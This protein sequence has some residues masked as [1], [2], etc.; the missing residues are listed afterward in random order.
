MFDNLNFSASLDEQRFDDWL[1]QGR[2]SK[3]GY[4]HMVILWD[5]TQKEY[6]PVYLSERTEIAKYQDNPSMVGDVLVAAYDLY[7]ESKVV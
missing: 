4:S 5:E 2:E 6:R 7:S 1:V 3:L